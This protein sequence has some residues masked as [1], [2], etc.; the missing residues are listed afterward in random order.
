MDT[1][2]KIGDVSPR[3]QYTANGTQVQ[4][5]YPFAIFQNADLQVYLNE[6]LQGSGYTIMGAGDSAGGTVEFDSAPST[7]VTVTLAR[8]LAIQRTSDFQESGA[9]RSKVI[10]DELDYLS[11]ALQQVSDDQS[12][13]VQ[14]AITESASVDTTLPSPRANGVLAW[15]SLGSGFVTGPTVD[16]VENA[17]MHATNA[18]ASASASAASAVSAAIS[19][20]NAASSAAAAHAVSVSPMY[21]TNESKSADFSVVA[22]DDGKQFLIDTTT[23]SVTVT[24]PE[25][26]TVSDG[27]R[28]AF[29]KTSVDNNAIIITSVGTDTINGGT[30]WQFSSPHG[31]SVVT[32]DTTPAPDTWFAAGVGVTAP[33]GVADLHIKAKPYDMAFVAGYDMDMVA[34]DLSVKTY[35]KLTVGHAGTFTGV[36]ANLTTAPVGSALILDV[37]K[38]DT[39]IFTTPPQFADTSTILTAST[40]KA[41]GSE[42]FVA[43]DEIT[44]ACIQVGSTTAGAGLTF[45][46]TAVLR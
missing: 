3:I 22:V 45:T 29:G 16:E 31:Q 38:N 9:F 6:D 17:Q 24:L 46:P 12:R 15:N 40:L 18:S 41:D 37:L 23:G 7:S 42:N 44:F 2:I 43:G 33:V 27:F 4:F 30:A 13:S 20:S 35:A 32:L 8:R 5:T 21:A 28:A 19:E 25:G 1:H 11:A 14:M 36:Y 34:E 10:N 26:I 39:T